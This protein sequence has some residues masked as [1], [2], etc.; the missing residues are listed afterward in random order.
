[1]YKII[2]L[3]FQVEG[4]GTTVQCS[5]VY[6][7]YDQFQI[8]R[9]LFTFIS[10]FMVHLYSIIWGN[11]ICKVTTFN[12]VSQETWLFSLT[13]EFISKMLHKKKIQLKTSFTGGP[14]IARKCVQI[15]LRA[16]RIPSFWIYTSVRAKNC[17]ISLISLYKID[18]LGPKS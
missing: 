6:L 12:T 9:I 11:D 4:E 5:L 17:A 3:I 15:N 1:M 14:R 16:I 10:Y 7:F 8:T 13:N 18:Y 2:I